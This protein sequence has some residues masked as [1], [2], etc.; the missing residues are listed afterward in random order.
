MLRYAAKRL[1]FDLAQNQ[2]Q[3]YKYNLLPSH[4]VAKENLNLQVPARLK[5][6]TV[7]NNIASNNA[8]KVTY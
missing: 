2:E 4:I 3:E 6:Y 8:G 1:L 7:L 5:R